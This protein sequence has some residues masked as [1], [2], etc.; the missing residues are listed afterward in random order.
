MSKVED[1]DTQLKIA[2][3]VDSFRDMLLQKNEKYGNSALVPINIFCPV[4]H[5]AGIESRID[6]K[7]M[8]VRTATSA[9]NDIKFNDVADLIGYLFLLCLRNDW[10]NFGDLID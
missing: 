6:D 3:M 4:G 8:R 9:G 5:H 1:I 7:L 2:S 10:T